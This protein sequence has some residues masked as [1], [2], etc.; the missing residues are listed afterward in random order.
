L[1]GGNK[2]IVASKKNTPGNDG[3]GGAETNISTG[4]FK[5]VKK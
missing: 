3:G 2:D 5:V 4:G 1:D